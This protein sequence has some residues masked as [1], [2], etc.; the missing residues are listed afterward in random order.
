[1]NNPIDPFKTLA[2]NVI[3]IET[4]RAIQKDLD[5]MT[6]CGCSL[7]NSNEMPI[8]VQDMRETVTEVLIKSN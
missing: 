7:P 8:Y 5:N 1:M 6:I 3:N 4:Y 2:D